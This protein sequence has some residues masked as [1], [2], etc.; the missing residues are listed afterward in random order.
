MMRVV[1]FYFPQGRP[2]VVDPTVASAPVRI[3][4]GDET[5]TIKH[6]HA[7]Y[8]MRVATVGF[9]RDFELTSGSR[10]AVMGPVLVIERWDESLIKDALDS[11]V[12][13]LPDYAVKSGI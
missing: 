8:W 9:I 12:D 4:V 11:F 13:R 1:S 5:A 3:I 10:F 6:F 7:E 2:T